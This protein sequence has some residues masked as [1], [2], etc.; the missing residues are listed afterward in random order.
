MKK[1]LKY[2]LTFAL[3]LSTTYVK[4]FAVD[5]AGNETYYDNLCSVS[6]SDPSTIEL[7]KQYQIYL[8]EIANDR[9]NDLEDIQDQLDGLKENIEENVKKVHQYEDKII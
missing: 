6:L 2:V 3:I 5:F 1:I 9:L 8:N 4:V 7:C